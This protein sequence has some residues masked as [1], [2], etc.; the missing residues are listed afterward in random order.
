MKKLL[1]VT[2]ALVALTSIPSLA[3]ADVA[4]NVGVVTDYRYRAISQTRLKP[5][6]QGGV[7]YSS[8]GLYLGAWAS[9]IRWIKDAKGDS[10]IE[11]DLYGGYRGE[12]AKGLGYDVGLLSYVYSGNKLKP[13]ANTTEIYG[14]L[15]YGA[16]SA[17]YSHSTTNLFGF[18]RSSG[19][20]YLDLGASFE[21]A[22]GW[23]VAPHLGVQSVRRNSVYSYTDYALTLSKDFSGVAFSAALIAASVDKV[24][25]V[26]V[27]A[28]PAGKD[29]GRT[30]LV[31]GVKYSF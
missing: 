15:S 10:N 3:L 5:A 19:S 11:L 2:S 23:S 21:I 16:Y 1:L 20:G 25:G 22:D 29:L 27:Y 24:A 14:A 6:L 30:A 17:K 7:D 18:A 9:T 8:A 28:S 31:L 26:P 4:Y 12:I 13:S